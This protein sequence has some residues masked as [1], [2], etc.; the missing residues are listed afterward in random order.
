[1]KTFTNDH[2]C[3]SKFHYYFSFV[4]CQKRVVLWV[5]K[6]VVTVH[7]CHYQYA[8]CTVSR[9]Q[10]ASPSAKLLESHQVSKSIPFR[11][12]KKK[13]HFASFGETTEDPVKTF[14]VSSFFWL[15]VSTDCT[16]SVFLH[17]WFL[18][19]E[20]SFGSLRRI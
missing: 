6:V 4:C 12:D 16:V 3:C 17:S 8:V 9:P 11:L 20:L 2:A 5:R 15:Q 7:P 1:M 18:T 13:R 19:V 10:S 14:D